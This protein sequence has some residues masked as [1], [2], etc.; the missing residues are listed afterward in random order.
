MNIANS[1]TK[2]VATLGPA[3]SSVEVLEK[4]IVEGM[5]V[6]RINFSHG[7]HEFHKQTIENVRKVDE[8]LGTFTAILGDLQGPKIRIGDVENN[9]VELIN[10]EK[11]VITTS[12]MIG[13]SKKVYLTYEQFPR[14]VTVGD[15]ILIDDGK[16]MLEVL[17]TDLIQEVECKVL[18]GGILS[19]KKGVNLPNTKISLPCLTDKDLVDLKFA[20]EQEIHWIGLSFVRH[21]DDIHELRG[22]IKESWHDARIIA[23]IEKPEAV[24]NLNAIIRASDAIMVARGDLGVEIPMQEVPTVQKQIVKKCQK[25]AKPVIIA[26]QM[27]ES[28][29]KNISPTRAEVN[30]VANAVMDG[31]DCVMLSGE[32]S[33]GD[34]PQ[35]VIKT[36]TKIVLEIEQYKGIYYKEFEPEVKQERFVTDSICFQAARL[37]KNS[38]ARAILTMTFSGYTGFKISSFRP[39]A[40]VFVFT[41]NKQILAMMS[42]VW[43]TRAFFYDQFDST[44]GSL[45][46]I[47]DILVEKGHVKR[48]DLVV[49]T[50]ATPIKQKGMTNMLLLAEA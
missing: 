4:M 49:H 39:K 30:D 36:M 38:K 50:A 5:N 3:S 25:A 24:S 33:V 41:G 44:D 45:E 16:L 46:D 15:R 31:A 12:P 13:T 29:I 6:A 2:I 14:D 37:A 9:G 43:G 26:T 17:K 10:G 21:A 22:I 20:L 48:G 8:K 28:M 40:G 34:H 35:E 11:L 47:R 1:K 27:M 23:K 32:T 7:D 19:S 42:L 18:H